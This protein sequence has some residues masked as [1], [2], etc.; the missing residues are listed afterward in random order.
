VDALSHSLLLYFTS[1]NNNSKVIKSMM[2][3]NLEHVNYVVAKKQKSKQSY[4]SFF[5][6]ATLCIDYSSADSGH[7][8]KFMRCHLGCFL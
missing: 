5:K 6:V 4:F 1:Q 8:T 7:S 2:E 3:H